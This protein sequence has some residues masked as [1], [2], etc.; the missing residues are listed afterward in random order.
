MMLVCFRE[1]QLFT[2]HFAE[3]RNQN[4]SAVAVPNKPV[5][6]NSSIVV[7]FIN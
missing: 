4:E 1:R 3:S 7:E 2:N 6:T 5:I